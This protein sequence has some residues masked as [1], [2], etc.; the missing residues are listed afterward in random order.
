VGS[1]HIEAVRQRGRNRC[2]HRRLDDAPLMG[3]AAVEAYAR[4]K[5]V[6]PDDDEGKMIE[7]VSLPK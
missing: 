5:A 4:A 7:I 1:A 6:A 2:P 3:R